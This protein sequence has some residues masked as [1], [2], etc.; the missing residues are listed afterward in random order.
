MLPCLYNNRNSPYSLPEV[1]CSRVAP[2]NK[3]NRLSIDTR[4]TRT[5]TGHLSSSQASPLS[6]RKYLE[7]GLHEDFINIMTAVKNK[8]ITLAEG[9]IIKLELISKILSYDVLPTILTLPTIID[10]SY[11][12]ITFS[13]EIMLLHD[14]NRGYNILPMSGKDKISPIMLFQGTSIKTSSGSLVADLGFS[15]IKQDLFSLEFFPAHDVGRQVVEKGS[16]YISNLLKS[17]QERGFKKSIM[18]GH[19]LG[20][21]LASSFAIDGQ[22]PEY[23]DLV[24]TFNAPGITKNELDKYRQLEKPF[25]ALAYTTE[26]DYIGNLIAPRRF[27][28]KQITIQPKDI[29][30]KLKT[31]HTTC[32]LSSKDYTLKIEAPPL[33]RTRL[34]LL[35]TFLRFILVGFI[36]SFAYRFFVLLIPAIAVEI[37]H[38]T[39][40]WDKVEPSHKAAHTYR[41]DL[42]NTHTEEQKN[43]LTSQFYYNYLNTG[44]GY[45]E[46]KEE[47]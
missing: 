46:K 10:N 1:S 26:G 29:P 23:I 41:N 33:T 47:E 8:E 13:V 35:R 17:N 30:L 7:N 31:K 3:P 22:N 38:K 34:K 32:V 45:L 27:Y 11:Q 4:I 20:G 37:I 21:K 5:L 36:V 9:E 6:P 16:T 19:S 14:G 18:T 40:V 44:N 28:K 39:K 43:E 25:E 15:A 42:N 24:I 12:L 2:S